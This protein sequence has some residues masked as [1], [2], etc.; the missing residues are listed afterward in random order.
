MAISL[1]ISFNKID[2]IIDEEMNSND[3]V[4]H[5]RRICELMDEVEI[6]LVGH[7]TLEVKSRLI[8]A[9]KELSTVYLIS[10]GSWD[11]IGVYSETHDI[12]NLSFS[13]Q[14]MLGLLQCKFKNDIIFLTMTR[15]IRQALLNHEQRKV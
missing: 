2:V 14:K 12:P 3:I 8:Y 4:K 5:Q 13:I 15:R 6:D 1:D 11:L 10:N 7:L 9:F